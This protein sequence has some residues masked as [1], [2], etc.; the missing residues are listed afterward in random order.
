MNA[1][2]VRTPQEDIAMSSESAI[3]NGTYGVRFTVLQGELAAKV[4]PHGTSLY[5][6]TGS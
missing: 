6:L 5:R 2:D 3:P 4:P 1:G